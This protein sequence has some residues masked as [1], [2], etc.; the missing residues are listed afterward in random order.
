M[1]G[2][3]F[4][5]KKTIRIANLIRP[6]TSSIEADQQIYVKSPASAH[7]TSAGTIFFILPKNIGLIEKSTTG[8]PNCYATAFFFLL[9]YGYYTSVCLIFT[10]VRRLV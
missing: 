2:G 8:E 1:T 6:V 10:C 4:N 5:L 9:V 7:G 3:K